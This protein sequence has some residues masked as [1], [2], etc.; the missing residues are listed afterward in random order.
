MTILLNGSKEMPELNAVQQRSLQNII[1]YLEAQ[2]TADPSTY[3]NIPY[4]MFFGFDPHEARCI[5]DGLEWAWNNTNSPLYV[6][7]H[8]I[9]AGFVDGGEL[10]MTNIMHRF[11][12]ERPTD[13]YAPSTIS[14]LHFDGANGSTTFTD[15]KGGT[16]LRPSSPTAAIST[17]HSKFGGS[18][19]RVVNS[20]GNGW[21]Y[22]SPDLSTA[23]HNGDHTI[24]AY[25]RLD[26]LSSQQVLFSDGGASPYCFNI[27]VKTNG[28]MMVNRQIGGADDLIAT[29]AAGVFTAGTWH[30]VAY[31]RQG[32]VTR[33]YLNGSLLGT[34]TFAPSS[35][36]IQGLRA[37]L[38]AGS[39]T[40][41]PMLGYLDF[42]RATTDARYRGNSFTPPTA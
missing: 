3:P 6:P 8:I 25:A 17:T 13:L 27:T 14:V 4:H 26:N 9:N 1:D 28:S 15:T 11:K 38:G 42:F 16:W 22:A 29:T 33:L 24:E 12:T 41:E 21:V 37:R 39:N 7:A 35:P 32:L 10:S 40:G 18:S 19:L 23:F 2:S 36:G 20:G 31:E 34:G 5:R 30:H